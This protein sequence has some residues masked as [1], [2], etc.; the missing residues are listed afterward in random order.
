MIW[1][2]SETGDKKF[3]GGYSDLVRHFMKEDHPKGK[4]LLNG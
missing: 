3:I 4:S 2:I 1:E